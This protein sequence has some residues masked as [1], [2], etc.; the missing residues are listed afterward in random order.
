MGTTIDDLFPS[1]FL[2]AADLKGQKRTLTISKITSEEV[3]KDKKAE[4]IIYFQKCTK[5]LVLNKTNAKRIAEVLGSKALADWPGKSVAL[6]SKMV[7]FAG[8]LVPAIRIDAASGNAAQLSPTSWR[9]HRKARM[10]YSRTMA[11]RRRLVIS[12]TTIFRTFWRRVTSN[13]AKKKEACQETQV[14]LRRN[15]K[16]LVSLLLAS[17]SNRRKERTMLSI[18][19]NEKNGNDQIAEVR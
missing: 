11:R 3:G 6:Y 18:S 10:R 13:A 14:K 2:K 7:E 8:D 15:R 12:P 16:G 5:G 19:V 17:P 1:R 9:H 4:P